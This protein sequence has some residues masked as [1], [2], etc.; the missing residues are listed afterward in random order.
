MVGS[1][2]SL[3]WEIAPRVLDETERRTNTRERSRSMMLTPTE[4]ILEYAC[5]LIGTFIALFMFMAPVSDVRTA[6]AN[7]T[8]GALN[9]TP[10]AV[11]TGNCIGWVAYSYLINS[12]WVFVPNAV[13]FMISIWLN[14]AAVKLQY[15]D[16][17]A[18]ELRSSFVRLLDDNRKSFRGLDRR[19]DIIINDRIIGG[20]GKEV[21]TNTSPS[22]PPPPPL[23][24]T[25]VHTF[26]NLRNMALEVT[27][28]K[29]EAPAPHEKVVIGFIFIWLAVISLLFFIPKVDQERY[30]LII[31]IVANVNTFFFYGAPL[32][33]IVTVLRTSDSCSIHRRTMITNTANAVF[34]SAFGI[35]IMDWIIVI[36]NGLGSVLGFIQVFLCLVIPNRGGKDATA[37]ADG[38]PTNSLEGLAVQQRAA[39]KEEETDSDIEATASSDCLDECISS[40]TKKR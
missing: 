37:A 40:S 30:T 19:E 14:M 20:D 39:Q 27:T 7:G 33:T 28:Q 6:V 23:I 5:P 26:V 9:P 18:K 15:S 29:M 35:G 16:R 1:L 25:P 12:L 22:S 31:G 17:I 4:I 21:H 38:V 32:S 24:P 34:W 2:L 3:A 11:M 13:G 10:W 8:L 36:P